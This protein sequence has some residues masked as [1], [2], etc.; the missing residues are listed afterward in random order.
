MARRILIGLCALGF[1]AL[2]PL[3]SCGE[4]PCHTE[5]YAK[6]ECCENSEQTAACRDFMQRTILSNLPYRITEEQAQGCR[7]KVSEFKCED[8]A[9]LNLRG[10][11]NPS[12]E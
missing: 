12:T 11:C 2:L 10:W 8:E 1:L 9:P 3:Q 6:C 5:W 7:K 4:N